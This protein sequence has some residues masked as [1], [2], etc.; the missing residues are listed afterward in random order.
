MEHEAVQKIIKGQV[1]LDVAECSHG[2]PHTKMLPS[3]D[4]E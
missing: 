1:M 4:P 3:A 2:A